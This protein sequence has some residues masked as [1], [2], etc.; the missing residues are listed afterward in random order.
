MNPLSALDLTKLSVDA[1][2][3]IALAYIALTAHRRERHLSSSLDYNR[4]DRERLML[5]VESNT[6]AM[7]EHAEASRDMT[8]VLH[9]LLGRTDRINGGH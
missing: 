6:R 9:Q 2:S 1:L 4:K 5:V 7:E 3:I 8:K